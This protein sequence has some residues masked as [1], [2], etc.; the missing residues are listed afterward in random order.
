MPVSYKTLHLYTINEITGPLRREIERN[1]T[2]KVVKNATE[3]W[4]IE[5][6]KGIAQNST[7]LGYLY[8]GMSNTPSSFPSKQ[9]AASEVLGLEEYLVIEIPR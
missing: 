1:P 2:V 5:V 6:H 7:L 4:A 9:V 3:D 8:D